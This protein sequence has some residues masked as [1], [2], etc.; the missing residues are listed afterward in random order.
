MRKPYNLT[1]KLLNDT[2]TTWNECA[3]T[4]IQTLN[5]CI[6]RFMS[7]YLYST[8]CNV[9][10]VSL[11][12]LWIILG[13]CLIGNCC[14][15]REWESHHQLILIIIIIILKHTFWRAKW[16]HHFYISVCMCDSQ[17]IEWYWEFGQK[18]IHRGNST[19]SK[20]FFFSF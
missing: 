20:I 8:K 9:H 1:R 7:Y 5:L 10:I 16:Q 6:H 4:H 19:K 18:S 3:H 13:G 14:R 2:S 15:E 17:M 11:Q 12:V